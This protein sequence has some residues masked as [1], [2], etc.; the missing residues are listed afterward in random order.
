[1]IAEEGNV[2]RASTPAAGLQTRYRW[3][4]VDGRFAACRYVG[5][6][7]NLQAD[8]QSAFASEAR[9]WRGYSPALK[10]SQTEVFLIGRSVQNRGARDRLRPGSAA[11]LARRGSPSGLQYG[12]ARILRLSLKFFTPLHFCVARP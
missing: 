1:M 7:G 12:Y 5:Q 8:C 9:V 3:P 10:T 11:L 4:S 6:V 2:G